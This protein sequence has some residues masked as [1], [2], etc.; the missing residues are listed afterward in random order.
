MISLRTLGTLILKFSCRYDSVVKPLHRVLDCNTKF[1]GLTK[2]TLAGAT[3]TLPEVQAIL[4]SFL[5]P[6]SIII[7]HSLESDLLTLHMCHDYVIDTSVLYPHR[8]GPPKKRALKNL[9]SEVLRKI[10]QDGDNGHDSAEDAQ[11]A[12]ELVL[13][14]LKSDLTCRRSVESFLNSQL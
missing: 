8:M 6:T 13:H 14:K 4:L 5:K 9:S 7:G 12:V 10:I 2:E 1:S 11:V 3:I